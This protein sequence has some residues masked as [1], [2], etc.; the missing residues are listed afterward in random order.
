MPNIVKGSVTSIPAELLNKK[1]RGSAAAY[2]F[3]KLEVGDHYVFD[4]DKATVAKVR[5][6]YTNYAKK[7][8]VKLIGTMITNKEIGQEQTKEFQVWRLPDP[9]KVVTE[10]VA[11]ATM[12][13]VPATEE[14]PSEVE[15]PIFDKPT[16]GFKKK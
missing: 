16:T 3:D 8:D 6:A 11:T 7:H 5:S 13:T 15:P 12:E 10:A 4:T 9:V 1:G 14:V 2:E